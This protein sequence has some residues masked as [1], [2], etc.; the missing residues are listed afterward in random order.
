VDILNLNAN[1]KPPREAGFKNLGTFSPHNFFQSLIDNQDLSIV[2]RVEDVALSMDAIK[3]CLANRL[4]ALDRDTPKTK[5]NMALCL[6]C[7]K[8]EIITAH[9]PPWLWFT[10]PE[11]G[12]PIIM[13]EYQRAIHQEVEEYMRRYVK[14]KQDWKTEHEEDC[15]GIN[16]TGPTTDIKGG[17]EP[18]EKESHE[19]LGS[20]RDDRFSNP[21]FEMVPKTCQG[22]FFVPALE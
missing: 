10:L 20:K 21:F 17:P 5:V 15:W 14:E 18:L 4:V 3:S 11:L 19:F 7:T 8:R 13:D 6:A 9:E 2:T 12:F 16:Y 22:S 1:S